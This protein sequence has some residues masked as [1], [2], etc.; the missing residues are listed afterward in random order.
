MLHPLPAKPLFKDFVQPEWKA[1]QKHLV[2]S[3]AC[4]C[5]QHLTSVVNLAEQNEEAWLKH[6]EEQSVAYTL[7]MYKIP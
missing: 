5:G 3:H 2:E 1:R 7:N 6:R 4:Y